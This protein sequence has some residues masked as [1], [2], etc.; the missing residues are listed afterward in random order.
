MAGPFATYD[1][2]ETAAAVRDGAYHLSFD[3]TGTIGLA[4][5]HQKFGDAIVQ[6]DARDIGP[7]P[8]LAP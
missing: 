7:T 2:P 1:Y 3:D 4:E 6:A 8:V 5:A